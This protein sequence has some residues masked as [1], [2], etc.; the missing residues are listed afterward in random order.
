MLGRLREEADTD[1][2]KQLPKNASTL[3]AMLSHITPNL[4]SFGVLVVRERQGNGGRRMI[5]ITKKTVSSVSPSAKKESANAVQ[6]LGGK[7]VRTIS[8]AE[9][10]RLQLALEAA[11]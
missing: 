4:R 10:A 11:A 6:E 2:E 5:H 8:E 9:L 7:T 1:E 3:S